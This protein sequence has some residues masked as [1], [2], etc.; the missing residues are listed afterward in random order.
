MRT[1]N[2]TWKKFLTE[3][4]FGQ[5]TPPADEESKELYKK[6]IIKLEKKDRLLKEISEDEME[7]IRTAI[8]EMSGEDLAFDKIFD[9]KMRLILDFPTL[10]A[11]TELGR[12]IKLWDD[13][14][15]T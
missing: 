1:F 10:D 11:G 8:D 13:L 9:G 6:Q 2:N 12:F 7:H 4:G 15:Y 5:G 3:G 14:G